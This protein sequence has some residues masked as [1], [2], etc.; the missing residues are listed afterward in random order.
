VS[1]VDLL[2]LL[3][4]CLHLNFTYPNNGLEVVLREQRMISPDKIV[5]YPLRH[6]E[7]GSLHIFGHAK[8]ATNVVIMCPGYPDDQTVF[9]PLAQRLS[10][11][12]MLVGIVCLPGYDRTLRH[13]L[14]SFHEIVDGLREAIQVLRQDV[15]PEL[16]LFGIFHDW[17]CLVGTMYANRAVAIE[18]RKELIPDRLI[19]LDVLLSPRGARRPSLSR[20]TL[21][22][23]MVFVLY[24][25]PLAVAFWLY[26][27]IS[28]TLA[29]AVLSLTGRIIPSLLLHHPTDLK[30]LEER[31]ALQAPQLAYP[32][33]HAWKSLF[34]LQ[35]K[36][37]AYCYLPKDLT[38]M[39]VLFLHGQ[40]KKI[41]LHVQQGE[42]ALNQENE[43]G[44]RSKVVAIPNGGHW[45]YLSDLDECW[46]HI[47]AFLQ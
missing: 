2:P 14:W 38:S 7:S 47:Q 41:P 36:E 10:A 29:C 20:K 44:N 32:Y 15:K 28:K 12:G 1:V 5:S 46:G 42:D 40:H 6:E 35:T 23:G 27:Y 24:Q 26:R 8:D 17:G 22:Q 18:D 25:F 11:L 30:H 34:T 39:P 33:Y 16:K 45:F 31:Q 37:F 3:E 13:D 21:Y 9:Y 43:K 4:H 19:L